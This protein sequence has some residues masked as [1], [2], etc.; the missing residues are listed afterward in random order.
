MTEIDDLEMRCRAVSKMFFQQ[1]KN[2]EA[3]LVLA[4]LLRGSEGLM[5][6]DLQRLLLQIGHPLA[7]EDI[8]AH[9]HSLRCKGL[10]T[11]LHSESA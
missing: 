7:F 1:G 3:I 4:Y 2:E 5:V 8:Q 10:I 9:L 6:A 11:I